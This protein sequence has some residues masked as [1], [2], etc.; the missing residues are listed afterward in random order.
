MRKTKH[1]IGQFTFFD[2]TG[3]QLFLEK[4][5]RK[6][7]MLE[8]I[9]YF[10]WRFRRIEPAEL[11]FAVT[12]FPEAGAY[13]P[14]PSDRELELREMCAHAGWQHI[15]SNSQMQIYCNEQADPTP[16]ETDP[17]MELENIHRAAKKS[18][19]PV[20]GFLLAVVLLY[21][22]LEIW[23][24]RQ[25]P[26][27]IL[28]SNTQLFAMLTT[29][30]LAVMSVV[31][32]AGYILWRRKALTAAREQEQF[33][34][35]WGTRRFMI[36]MLWLVAAC[37]V[38]TLL[39]LGSI[40]YLVVAGVWIVLY[41]LVIL[42]V[43]GGRRLMQRRDVPGKKNLTVTFLAA[44]VLYLLL[45]NGVMP[46]LTQK[47]DQVWPDR[48]PVQIQAGWE[49]HDDEIPLTLADLGLAED[50]LYSTVSSRIDSP[51]LG[52]AISYQ[53]CMGEQWPETRLHYG[54]IDVK[55]G[56]LYDICLER[57][58]VHD[59]KTGMVL[60]GEINYDAAPQVDAAPWGAEAAYELHYKGEPLH[61]W[62]LCY[63]DRIVTLNTGV[64]L[65]EAQMAAVGE[66]FG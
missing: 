21:M 23:N 35:T 19:L 13:D 28:A 17:V 62:L 56:F 2:R 25:D 58:L 7:W 10:G 48:Q 20:Y 32:I 42:A 31:E 43:Q 11:H 45:D 57:L 12:Y 60:Y 38:G 44:L 27:G 14:G 53:S 24:L 40:K 52:R 3:I 59:I 8:R 36:G 51:F 30:V 16:I 46:M 4:Q 29:V 50:T 6:G 33:L 34:P 47:L 64:A 39:S 55:M 63:E 41:F 26:I 65:D 61:I 1:C 5:A 49:I 15:A 22:A 9:G 54:V 37:L 18:F 66:I